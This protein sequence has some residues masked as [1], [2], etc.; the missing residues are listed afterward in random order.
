M[1]KYRMSLTAMRSPKP[2]FDDEDGGARVRESNHRIANN[3]MTIATLLRY[4]T[5]Q[6]AK[7]NRSFNADELREISNEPGQRIELVGRLHPGRAEPIAPDTLNLSP[8][9]NDV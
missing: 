9:L 2:T 1:S 6:L 4:Q 7:A 8:Y 5:R 3:L